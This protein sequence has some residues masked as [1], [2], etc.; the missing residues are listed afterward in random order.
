MHIY[1]V[2]NFRM[3]TPKAHGIQVAKM[4]EAFIEAG[5][6]VTLVVPTRHTLPE[7]VRTF[8]GLRTE[9][10][11]VRISTVDWYT[12][13]RLLYRLSSLW[14]VLSALLFLWRRRGPNTY[15][16]AIDA[17]NWSYSYLPLV[18][19]PCLVEMHGTK[20]STAS[21]RYFFKHTSG[22]VAINSII[23]NRLVET[24]GIAPSRVLVEP[25]AV[26]EQ[27][28]AP[29]NKQAARAALNIA[30]DKQLVLYAGRI[31]GWKG[32]DTFVSAAHYL[33]DTTFGVVGGTAQEL[34]RLVG[35]PLP[36]N[37]VCYGERPYPEVPQWI[38]AADVVVVSG[39]RHDENSYWWT[40]P[41]KL[42]EYM[43]CGATIVAAGT[44]ALRDA[45]SEAEV[46]WY[47]PDDAA[48]MHQAIARALG[49]E[50]TSRAQA[51]LRG[52]AAHTWAGRA[53]RV[54]AFLRHAGDTAQHG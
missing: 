21:T 29:G 16:Y 25:D 32:L 31:L 52:T 49:P 50:G 36:A 34:E 6:A 3:P 38:Q 12:K 47:E 14:F 8:Y 30:H 1:F 9:V 35:A 42:Y 46:F 40:S 10:P 41:M 2:A 53:E 11:V 4:C 20:P 27:L 43:A 13:G 51:A 7:S 5:A 28:F 19:M 39:T 48:S 24:F 33:S 15:V 17:D 37:V 23:K 45:V 44:P 18:G 54:L 22:V 26:D